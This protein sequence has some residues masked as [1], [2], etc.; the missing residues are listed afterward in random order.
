MKRRE[1]LLSTAIAG[2]AATADGA[3]SPAASQDKPPSAAPPPQNYYEFAA[4]GT[5]CLIKRAD[6]PIPW[7]NLLTNDDFQ[8]WITHRGQTECFLLDR[9]LGGLTNPQEV[10]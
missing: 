2:S 10:S 4:G 3:P 1:F 5:E 8:T 9:G 6:T 7:M